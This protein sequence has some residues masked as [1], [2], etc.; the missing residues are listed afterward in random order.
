[1]LN[2]VIR[3]KL[4]VSLH[5]LAIHNYYRM[6]HDS[7]TEE[8]TAGACSYTLNPSDVYYPLPQAASQLNSKMCGCLHRTR[9]LC[10]QCEE[11]YRQPAYHY[12]YE[13]VIYDN[14]WL[15]YITLAFAPL[16]FFLFIVFCFRISATSAQ[17][18]A[19]VY[20]S[21]IPSAPA[22]VRGI[23]TGN[24]LHGWSKLVAHIEMTSYGIYI[25]VLR[26][27]NR[28]PTHTFTHMYACTKED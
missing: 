10:G 17:L 9:Q 12:S 5:Y 1:M 23:L 21:Q 26:A 7:S 25:Y 24:V 3:C 2:G 4:N 13:C 27:Q 18:N 19:F 22:C 11:K 20:C 15:N 28:T 16:T 6:T 8:T 14:N